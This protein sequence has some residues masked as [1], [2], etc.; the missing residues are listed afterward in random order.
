M[1]QTAR[2]AQVPSDAGSLSDESRSA[3]DHIRLG[4]FP[5]SSDHVISPVLASEAK[6]PRNPQHPEAARCPGLLR[7]ARKD[8]EQGIQRFPKMLAGVD[9]AAL[10]NAE[11]ASI[12]AENALAVTFLFDPSS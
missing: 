4:R 8:G 5:S 9:L 3:C 7:F 11:P 6:Q 1:R 10:S 2:R 12:S